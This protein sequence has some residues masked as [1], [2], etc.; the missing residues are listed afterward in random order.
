MN[1]RGTLTMREAQLLAFLEQHFE[2]HH[3][4]PLLKE[5]AAAVNEKGRTTTCALRAITGLADKGFL[6]WE[7]RQIRT[8]R[9]TSGERGGE[10]H[11]ETGVHHEKP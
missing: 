7:G 5:M 9:L 11:L 10:Q 4:A 1:K 3:Y 6:T 8:I 2:R